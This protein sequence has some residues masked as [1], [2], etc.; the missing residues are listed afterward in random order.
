MNYRSGLS[1]TVDKVQR[2][3]GR[4]KK[5]PHMS[6]SFRVERSDDKWDVDV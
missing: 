3:S 4:P 6:Q 2:Y 5:G 1:H